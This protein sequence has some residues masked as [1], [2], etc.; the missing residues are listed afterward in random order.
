[1]QVRPAREA[2]N[3]ALIELQ[4]RCPQGSGM[5]TS[6]VNTPD[7][8]A[9]AKA[10]GEH[11]VFV[12]EQGGRIAASGSCGIRE[13]QVGGKPARTGYLFDFFAA[14]EQRRSGL[15]SAVC[16][17]LEAHLRD[18]RECDLVYCLIRK[19]NPGSRR[20]F[21][22]RG[23]RARRLLQIKVMMPYQRLAGPETGDLRKAKEAD[24]PE[25][26]ELLDRTWR[27]H[28]LYQPADAELL[29][30][31][32]RRTPGHGVDK[33]WLL[34]E[35]DGSLA[36]CAGAWD[37]SAI[38]RLKVVSTTRS[39]RFWA[40]VGPVLARFRK[41]PEFP[42]GGDQIDQW[43]LTTIGFRAPSHVA[44]LL[45]RINDE[46]L[47]AGVGWVFLLADDEPWLRP[48]LEGHMCGRAATFLY[49]RSF[50]KG[51]SFDRS[52][53]AVDGIHL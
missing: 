36:A 2:D 20:L 37:W 41:F 17:A 31:F 42:R 45:R 10:L 3:Q 33:L 23:Y 22:S 7:F 28:Q 43:C 14:P 15:A 29:A 34:R 49:S 32:V 8:F 53:L 1:M 9:R 47:A 27:G 46:A 51:V 24:L 13:A 11:R 52:P 18:E 30:D 38:T 35:R 48:A 26:A 40:A 25:I 4:A 5:V 19:D 16:D 6:L 21:E 12:V 39:L 50:T 44:T